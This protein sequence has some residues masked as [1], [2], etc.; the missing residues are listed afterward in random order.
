MTWTI[1][2]PRQSIPSTLFTEC[3]LPRSRDTQ[4]PSKSS[5]VAAFD[6]MG[7]QYPG[8]F[9]QEPLYS[10]SSPVNPQY[11][12]VTNDF[13]LPPSEHYESSYLPASE[14]IEDTPTSLGWSRPSD[15]V[16]LYKFIVPGKGK[17]PFLEHLLVS[18]PT[19]TTPWRV[20]LDKTK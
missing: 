20:Y 11:Y 15:Y 1:C 9:S 12:D 18:I 6:N 8:Y 13:T 7:S 17:R 4:N 10:P 16:K 3:Q 19:P 5:P 2:S 14:S